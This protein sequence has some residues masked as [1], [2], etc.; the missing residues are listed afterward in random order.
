MDATIA[1]ASSAPDLLARAAQLS[2]LVTAC[3][4]IFGAIYVVRNW[5][6]ANENAINAA[7]W[8]RAELAASYL[9]PL[10]SDDELAFAL[11]CLDWGVGRMVVPEKHRIMMGVSQVEHDPALVVRA[12]RPRLTPDVLETPQAMLYRLAIDALFVRLEF[13]GH[14]VASG[15]IT[16]ADI[17]D[18]ESYLRLISD[19]PYAP[20]GD[21]GT[22][23]F[24]PFLEAFNYAQ[25]LGLMQRLDRHGRF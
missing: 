9:A 7:R 21:R 2:P 20:Q 15:L 13:I 23:V 8:K 18:I 19:W 11:R 10:F 6:I 22:D 4:A 14:R 16:V 5:R 1:A 12:M 24:R 25:T 3:V 17:R